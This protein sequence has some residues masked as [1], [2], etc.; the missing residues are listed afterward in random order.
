MPEVRNGPQPRRRLPAAQRRELIL[1]E[2][3]QAF[4]EA[5]NGVGGVSAKAIA[6]RCGVNE[7]LIFRHFGTKEDLFIEA[8][9]E[10]LGDAVRALVDETVRMPPPPDSSADRLG[11]MWHLTYDLL[12]G[13]LAMPPDVVRSI[14]MLLFG[15]SKETPEFYARTLEPALTAFESVVESEYPNWNHRAFSARLAVR[16]TLATCFWVVVE[17]DLSGRP[18]D[19]EGAARSLADLLIYG[20]AHPGDLKRS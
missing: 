5:G 8:V 4:L 14:A 2:A 17:T 11:R 7:A 19:R 1:H 9:L 10:P 13:L 15:K 12:I 20:M 3:R 6:E 16:Q 18:L